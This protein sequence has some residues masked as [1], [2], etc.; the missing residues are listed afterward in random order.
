MTDT[1]TQS[2][3]V[4]GDFRLLPAKRQLQRVDGRNIVLRGKVFDLLWYLIRN[5]GRLVDKSELLQA[6]WPDTVVEEN[7]LNQSVSALRQALGDD[8]KSPSYIA[9]VKGRGYQFVGEVRRESSLQDPSIAASAASPAAIYRHAPLLLAA[10]VVVGAALLWIQREPQPVERDPAIIEHFA[11]A[12]MSIVTDFAG[13]HSEP[14]LSP[15]GRMMAYVSDVTGTPQIWVKNLQRGD[16]IQ[17]TRGPYPAS[18]PSWS[19]SDDQ[20]LFQRTSSKN[21]SIYSVGTLGS[22]EATMIVEFGMDPNHA[23]TTDAFVYSTGRRIWIATNDGRDR[24]EILGVPSS[25]GFADREPALS[26]DG[27]LVAFV[28]ADEGP[29]GNLWLI[30]SQGGE[31]R[32]LTTSDTSSGIVSAPEWSSDGKFIIYSVD[33]DINGGQIW[34]YDVASGETSPLTTGAGGA[35]DVKLSNDGKRLLYTSTRSVWRLTRIDSLTQETSSIYESREPVLLPIASPDGKH[36]VFFTRNA[37][38]MQIIM[39]DSD[40]SNLRQLTFDDPGENGL[41]TWSGD[42]SAILYY[43]GRSLHR[44]DPSDGTDTELFPDFHWSSRNWLT[45]FGD[46]LSYHFIDRPN[47]IQRTIVRRLGESTEIELPVPIE[48]AQWSLDGTEL[49]GWSRQTGEIL[50]CNPDAATCR[51]LENDGEN[52]TGRRPMWS[53]DGQQIYFVRFNEDGG[54]CTLWRIDRDGGNKQ[55]VAELSGHDL[56]NSYYGIDADGNIF[57][58]HLD[59]STDEIWLADSTHE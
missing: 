37:T 14:T 48:A 43:R 53:N 8:V 18:S 2:S 3:Y 40:G 13:S 21:P 23:R 56:Q 6:L 5:K 7:N 45:A 22:P 31:A 55:Q 25:Q 34:R 28:H 50:F 16:P 49:I 9:T 35:R 57:H 4:F 51:N 11:D 33:A 36:I 59:R 54:C 32:Q 44:L 10:I 27:A 42:G 52:V 15:D 29:L 58:N 38:G 20:I 30:P 1:E 41:P 46:R 39:I 24:E 26:P 12:T 47:N 19:P 17:I